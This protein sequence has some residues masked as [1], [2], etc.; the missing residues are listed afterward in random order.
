M[1]FDFKIPRVDCTQFCS[2]VFNVKLGRNLQELGICKG[3]P[4]SNSIC[5]CVCVGGGGG[6][7]SGLK[8]LQL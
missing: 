5:L 4:I 7:G 2:S 8:K 3:V 1:N 6:R